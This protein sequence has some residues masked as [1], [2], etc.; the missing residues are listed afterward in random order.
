MIKESGW[1]AYPVP[2]RSPVEV[3]PRQADLVHEVI[4]RHPGDALALGTDDARVT[5]G[6]LRARSNRLARHLRATGV[7]RGD[8]VAVLLPRGVDG[9]VSV[10]AALTAGAAYLPIDAGYPAAR[11]RHM[12]ADSRARVLVTVRSLVRAD[13]VAPGTPVVLLDEDQ[14]TLA[15]YPDSPPAVS[16]GPGD[17]AYVIYT[18]GSTGLPKGVMVEHGS[19][20]GL[21]RWRADAER[22]GPDDRCLHLFSPGFDASVWDIWAPLVAGASLWL[23]DDETRVDPDRLVDW[24]AAHAVT[25]ATM[26]TPLAEAVL[27]RP[28]PPDWALRIL[29]AG[30][31]QLLA[32][33][34]PD[35][36]F[37]T[38]NLYGPTEA[39]V[40]AMS[41]EVAVEGDGPP[42]LGHPAAGA[43]IRL[44]TDDLRPVPAGSLG[45]VFISGPGVARGYHDRPALTAERFPPDP[46][47]PPGSRLYRTGD[48]ARQLP[49]GTYHFAGRVDDQVKL[50]GHRI[51]LGEI[52]SVLLRHPGVR[53]AAVGL[54]QGTAGP[55]LVGYVVPEV[56][57][58]DATLAAHAARYLPATM[59]PAA[60]VRLAELPLTPHGKLDR[61]ALPTP[62]E[63]VGEPP[64]DDLERQV[65][66]VWAE[67]LGRP[68]GRDDNFFSLGGHSLRATM[69]AV[70]LRD[71]FALPV[72][73]AI[74][75]EAQTVAAMAD[76]LR[77]ELA[78]LAD[79]EEG[80][81][82]GP[83]PA[84]A[85]GGDPSSP[86]RVLSFA[87]Q[88][89]WF[90]HTLDPKSTAYNTQTA[91]H[92]D[93]EL[94]LDHL[95]T[96][97]TEIARRHEVLRTTFTEHDGIPVQIIHPHP[98][99]HSTRHDLTHIDPHHHDHHI[100]DILR[101]EL[102]Q[103]FDLTTGPLLRCRILQLSDTAHVLCLTW[104]HIVLDGWSVGLFHTELNH[105][106]TDLTHGRTPALPPLPTQ[107]AD[108]AQRQ[109]HHWQ[110]T[111]AQHHL[112][113]LATRLRDAPPVC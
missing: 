29:G 96:A 33:P 48:L 32:R 40:L 100:R 22:L 108:I 10:L 110:S 84:V 1:S 7:G 98:N 31:Q 78:S 102:D 47:G 70:R 66:Q 44:L 43:A 85:P 57:P 113:E 52:E 20:R 21:A 91:W 25:S 19:L 90:L 15:A 26:P 65:A 61:N 77:A 16:I 99:H 97:I 37:T 38:V 69:V 109:R 72:S 71:R 6:E 68:P 41:G 3:E 39:T 93:G 94:N 86:G 24:L 75:F 112:D 17:L 67:V 59:V 103:P 101:A 45:E 30:G 58:D 50:H 106:Y 74:V 49:D 9:I 2:A 35:H 18:S 62:A 104:H 27:A 73:A 87:Q 107:Y 79:R 63:Q 51:E 46:Y 56:G 95:D 64:R 23:P 4:A 5:Y 88:R 54:H 12:L 36:T 105:L 111:H 76:R 14:A 80:V 13:L 28:A 60:W 83:D 55:R 34:R 42:A 81:P 53:A 82:S 11:V 92:I 89:L 8:L